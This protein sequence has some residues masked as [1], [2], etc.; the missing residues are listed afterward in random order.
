ITT[1]DWHL[2]GGILEEVH[3]HSTV[4]GKIWLIILFIFQM[5]DVA[6]EDI[7]DEQSGFICNTKQPG[8]RNVNVCYEQAFPIS[9]IRYWV[10]QVVFMSSPPLVYMSHPLYQPLLEKEGQ[11]MKI[12]LRRELDGVE[13]EM[14]VDQR[15]LERELCQLEQRKLNKAPFRGTLPCTYVLHIFT[16]SVEVGLMIGQEP[17]F[18]CHGHPCPNI[19]DFFV[20]RPT[21]MILFLLFIQSIA[22]VSFFSNILENFHLGFKKIKGLG[23][24]YKVK[25]E[26]NKFYANNSKQNLAKYQCISANSLKQQEHSSAPDYYLLVEKH[27]HTAASSAFKAGADNHSVNEEKCIFLFNVGTGSQTQDL[28]PARQVL[29]PLSHLTGPEKCILDEQETNEMFTISINCSH[30]HHISSNNN[31]DTNIFGKVTGSHFREKREIDGKTA[32]KKKKN[33]CSRGHSSI[34]RAAIETDN[35]MGQSPQTAFSLPATC[36]WKPWWL[37]AMWGPSTE[38]ENQGH[39]LK[40]RAREGTIRTPLPSQGDSQPLDINTSNSLAELSFEPKHPYD[41]LW[42]ALEVIGRKIQ[43][44]T[45]SKTFRG[46]VKIKM[47][48]PYL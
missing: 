27:T 28:V 48:N 21:K 3:I 44:I 4:T 29:T 22:I 47:K 31:K 1:G 40:L 41:D 6:A 36:I 10:Q 8:C 32:K 26:Y 30:L 18:K 12:Q 16:C 15:R 5:L 34:L 35:Y 17:L 42:K 9:L 37:S 19:I 33:H 13:F 38:D 43:G 7:N 39:L 46:V 23:G 24:Q 14:P 11:R 25:D 2:L 45:V 20:L